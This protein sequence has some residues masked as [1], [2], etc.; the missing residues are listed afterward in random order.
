[1][2]VVIVSYLYEHALELV[3][4]WLS[5]LA[6]PLIRAFTPGKDMSVSSSIHQL[7]GSSEPP[8]PSK[9]F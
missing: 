1:M 9:N 4:P 2:F 7:H 8:A 6:A 5:V 3:F